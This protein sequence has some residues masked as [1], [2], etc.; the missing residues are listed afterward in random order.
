MS[1]VCLFF[2]IY[3]VPPSFWSPLNG[4][5]LL[6]LGWP[7]FRLRRRLRW[8]NRLF[9]PSAEAFWP[10]LPSFP[11]HNIRQLFYFISLLLCKQIRWDMFSLL[12]K[13]GV[14]LSV[15]VIPRLN[16]FQWKEKSNFPKECILLISIRKCVFLFACQSSTYPFPNLQK[17]KKKT[18]SVMLL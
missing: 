6:P 9:W 8:E 13:T 10:T 12:A 11:F 7:T 2:S 5:P 17:N 3:S 1:F 4:K 14:G 15:C 18:R 16:T